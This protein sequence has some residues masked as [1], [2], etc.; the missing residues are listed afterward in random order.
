MPNLHEIRRLSHPV[1]G[2]KLYLQELHEVV[3]ADRDIILYATDFVNP[4]QEV[5]SEFLSIN[6]EDIRHFMTAISEMGA[7]RAKTRKLD[8]ILHSP[9]GSLAAAE[10][11]VNYLRAKYSHIRAIVPQNAMSAATMIACAADEIVMGRHSAL[12]PTDPQ[13]PV[14][15]HMVPAQAVLNEFYFAQQKEGEGDEGDE[16]S[17]ALE[18]M[19]ARM[20]MLPPGLIDTCANAVKLSKTMVSD[21]LHRYMKLGAKNKADEV[22]GKLANADENLTHDRP[23]NIEKLKSWGLKVKPLESDQQFQDA[24]LSVFHAATVV[25]EKDNAVKLV[26]NHSGAGVFR[27]PAEYVAD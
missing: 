24:V 6:D 22:A 10:Q 25:F 2:L 1:E 4:G 17:A 19:E 13:I 5:P 26:V 27:R 20:L 3:G 8:L 16:E 21:W 14:D 9:G 7:R 23:L 11:I 15:N 18:I 12:G